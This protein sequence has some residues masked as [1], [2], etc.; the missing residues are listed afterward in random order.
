[1][2]GERCSVDR[3]DVCV[4]GMHRS[5]TSMATRALDLLGASLGDPA[6][7]M[8]PGRDN[9]AGYWENRHIKELDDE[10]LGALGGS[11]DRPPVLAGDWARRDE[12]DELRGRAARV[13][14]QTFAGSEAPDRRGS[15]PDRALVVRAWKDPRLS[16][17]LPFWRTVTPIAATVMVVRDPMEVCASLGTRNDMAPASAALLWLRYVLAAAANDPG[18]LVVR[19]DDFFDDLPGTLRRMATHVGLP[20]PDDARVAAVTDHLHPDLRHHRRPMEAPADVDPVTAMAVRVWSSGRLDV[21]A[22]DPDTRRAVAEGWLRPPADDAALTEA[23]ARVTVLSERLRGRSR[24]ARALAARL[25]ELDGG[26][27]TAGSGP[28]TP[29]AGAPDPRR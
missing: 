11:W 24:E 28:H 13:L 27:P 14:D 8:P 15:A 7:L 4:T 5:G 3:L 6:A 2:P 23:R 25:Q 21:A 26:A 12:L 1:L 9:P 22:L 19:Y 29:G 10:L 16:L 17:V 20:A 18:H